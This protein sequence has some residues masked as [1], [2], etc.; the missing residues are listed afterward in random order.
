MITSHHP[1]P[2]P[3]SERTLLI[4]LPGIG[5]APTA[6]ADH[7]MIA[8][9]HARHPA[10]DIIPAHPGVDLYLDQN[11]AEI[12]HDTLIAPALAEGFKNIWLLG[13]SLGGMGALLY[14]A[15]HPAAVRGLILLA[16]FLGTQG[17]I[18]A[19]QKAGG[20]A[21]WSPENA[22]A[23]AI[24]QR[25]L[26][27]LQNATGGPKKIPDIYLGYGEQDR[28]A[29]G[30]RLLA[31]TLPKHRVITTPGGHDW[32]SWRKLW[33]LLLATSPFAGDCGNIA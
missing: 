17:T 9:L 24:E 29:P 6:F 27:W 30:H 13:I 8:A 26:L 28:F 31:A 23:T 18:A 1:A 5:F 11:L 25:A 7:G 16:P 4:M 14:A 32:D 33:M 22:V 21:A 19:I 2:S 20:L 12:L 10:I 15:A 3:S